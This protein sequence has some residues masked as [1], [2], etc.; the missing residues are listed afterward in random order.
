M[1]RPLLAR[2]MKWGAALLA[3]SWI[4]GCQGASS[5]SGL[6]AM[7]R[8]EGAQVKAGHITDAPENQATALVS[9]LTSGSNLIYPGIQGR[10]VSGKVGPEATA[11]AIGLAHDNDFWI[12][13][14]GLHDST[15]LDLLNF[16]AQLDF[17]PDLAGSSVVEQDSKGNPVVP[18]TFRAVT[19]DGRLGP[20]LILGMTVLS[21]E[22]SGSLVISL[23]W[24]APVDFDLRVLA[25][26]PDGTSTVEIWSKHASNVPLD[27]S[28]ALPDDEQGAVGNLDFD[29]NADC[30][31]DGRDQED[32]VWQGLPPAG[33]YVVR[34]DAFS[35][36]GQV[37]A[38]WEAQAT[39]NGQ[40]LTKS[41]GNPADVFGIATDAATRGDH[42]AGAGVR[43]FEFDLQFQQQ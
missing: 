25:P 39:Y 37:S 40:L 8:V 30:N 19:Q 28:S 24:D 16:S 32:V 29:S 7:L 18:I 5:S 12:L 10:N 35:L 21:N 9:G 22:P 36:C 27:M 43:A 41:D 4:S 11:V 6:T 33:H 3:L 15:S 13:P 1:A 20:S 38:E 42:G 17:S 34:V 31:I 23:R 2:G 14:A 26:S